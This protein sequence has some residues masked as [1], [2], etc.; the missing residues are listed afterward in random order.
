MEWVLLEETDS[1][2]RVAKDL[3]RQGAPHGTAVLAK[4]Q[5]AGRGRLGRQFFSPEGGLYLSV[6]LRPGLAPEELALMTPMAAVAVCRALEGLCGVSPRIKWVND[7]YLGDKKL[8]GILCEGAGG[9][10]IAGIGMNLQTPAGGFPEGVPA[11]A[12]DRPVDREALAR[13]IAGE[14]LAGCD[15]LPDTGFLQEYRS[16]NLVP[17]RQVTVHP[18][19]GE[20]YPAR[21]LDI[22]DR[23]RLVV[24]TARGKETLDGGEISIRFSS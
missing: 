23:G 1:T 15:A 22:D 4:S 10:V 20:A 9:A 21:A 17:G 18:V 19:K 24:E 11:V 5:R 16:R 8:C 6:I 12:L 14:L 7:L 2:N 3:A 13:A